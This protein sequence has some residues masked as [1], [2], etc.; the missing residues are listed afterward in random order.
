MELLLFPDQLWIIN[1]LTENHS[2]VTVGEHMSTSANEL[3][4]I[5][6]YNCECITL[7]AT[8]TRC[9][10]WALCPAGYENIDTS[11]AVECGIPVTHGPGINAASVAEAALMTILM[12]ARKV[13]CLQLLQSRLR[14][15]RS[16]MEILC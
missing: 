12:L 16:G 7:L 3:D 13:R 1:G 14:A 5:V 8:L 6:L 10:S 2:H 11:A 9:R 4:C 15:I